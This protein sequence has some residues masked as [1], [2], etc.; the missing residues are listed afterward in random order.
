MGAT[1][2]GGVELKGTGGKA[3][4]Q[5]GFI[6]LGIM[7]KPMAKHLLQAGYSLHVHNRSRGA[8]EELAALGATPHRRPRDVAAAADIVITMLPD[9][10]DV[11]KVVLREGGALEGMGPGKTLFANG[12]FMD[13]AGGLVVYMAESEA[14]VVRLVQQDPYIIHGARTSEIHEWELVTEAVLPQQ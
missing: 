7:G 10:P 1:D 6:G 14:D 4:M 2:R 12:R 11:E 13:G 9:S 3:I 5:I 8:V